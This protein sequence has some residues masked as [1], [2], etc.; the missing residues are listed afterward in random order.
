[1]KKKAFFIIL[2]GF[3]AAKNYLRP[4]SGVLSLPKKQYINFNLRY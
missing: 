3:S 4:N 2:K 1:M